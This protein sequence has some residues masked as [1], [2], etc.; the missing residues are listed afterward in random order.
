[1]ECQLE[2]INIYYE[3][4]GEGRPLVSLHGFAPDH[5]LMSG[6]IEPIFEHRGGWQ[7]IYLDLP[8][9]GETP[10]AEWIS[11]SDQMLDVVSDFISHVI[12]DQPF[13]LAGESY[14]GYL[15]RG[16]IYRQPAFVDGLLLICPMI[17]ADHAKRSLPP[18]TVLVQDSLFLSS[19][20]PSDR[21]EFE[22][23]TV[24]QNQRTWERTRDEIMS[25]LDVADEDFLSRLQAHGYPF[26]F[27][28]DAVSTPFEKPTLILLGRQDVSVGYRDA[29]PIFENYS[30]GMFAVLDRAG[31]NLQIEQETLFNA[32]V[33]EWLD[34]IEENL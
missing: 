20:E 24:V 23:F 11:N 22:S 1:M 19:L 2:N 29:W 14:G 25:G 6:C 16:I 32:L 27:D 18:H 10:G 33:N 7:R 8:G 4:Y 9:M 31:H 26:S 17:V 13:V 34:R 21:E 15:A 5:R 12:P 30:R 28:V 3:V